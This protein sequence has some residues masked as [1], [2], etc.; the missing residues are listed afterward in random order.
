VARNLNQ[1]NI[2]PGDQQWANVRSISNKVASFKTF[3][4]DESYE[5]NS[6]FST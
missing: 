4:P 2:W 3:A 5:K 6:S 1:S